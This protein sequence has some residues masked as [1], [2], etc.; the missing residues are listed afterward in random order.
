MW[1]RI[2]VCPVLLAAAT[3]L[4]QQPVS[5]ITGDPLS[6]FQMDG[7]GTLSVVDVTGEPFQ[8]ALH[9]ETPV[10]S[11]NLYDIRARCYSTST[12]NQGDV[13]VATFWM[14]TVSSQSGTGYTMFDVEKGQSPYSKS[15]LWPTRTGSDWEMKQVPFVMA[16]TYPSSNG[17]TANGYNIDFWVTFEPQ[18]IE[19]GGLTVLN[20]GPNYPLSNLG[21]SLQPYDG[22]DPNASWR[23][24]AAARIEQIRKADIVAVVHDANGNPLPGATVHVKMKRHAFPFGTSISSIGLL[25]QSDDAEKYRNAVRTLFNSAVIENDL[26]WP[27]WETTGNSVALPALDWLSQNG[28]TNLRG[29]NLIWPSKPNLPPDVVS[30]LNQPVVDQ[31]AL[32]ARIQSHFADIM[33]ATHGKLTDWDV[34]N[35]PYTNTDVQGVLGDDE[36]AAWF[37]QARAIDLSVKLYL[38]D[39]GF[40][41]SGG[42][43]ILHQDALYNH[44]IPTIL[45]SGDLDGIG[46]QA[47]FDVSLTP[48]ER[49]I[50]ILDRFAKF[51]KDIKITEFDVTTTDEQLQADYTRDFL[52]AVF[53]HPAVKGFTVWGFYEGAEWSPEAAMIRGDWTTKPN[54]DVWMNLVYKQWWT[55]VTGTT[56][57]DGT[58]RT[59][60]FLGDYDIDV[61]T[62]NAMQTLPLTVT[63]PGPNYL[64]MGKQSAGALTA[65]GVVNAAS[66]RGGSI[67]PGETIEIWGSNFGPAAPAFS[68][69]DSSGQLP[70]SV[71]D[72]RVLINGSP[73]PVGRVLPG[74]VTAIVPY[75][76]SGNATIQVQYLGTVTNAVTVPVQPASPGIFCYYGGSSQA[77][78]VNDL[79]DGTTSLNTA[80]HPVPRGSYVTIYVTGV[81]QIT[82]AEIVGMRPAAGSDLQPVLP[83]VV[84]FGDSQASCPYNWIGLVDAGVTQ[85]NACVPDNAP[86]G[87]AIPLSVTIGGIAAQTG[88]TIAIR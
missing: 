48:P 15:I 30:M 59:R 86:T 37:K 4:A 79:P 11:G 50:E 12:A 87:S 32:R 13:M 70:T 35:E 76:A 26:K 54:Y 25:V 2:I 43:D 31:N 77:V 38:N 23:A 45:A 16:E 61:T 74:R 60:G 51:G 6:C 66:F 67:A 58:F 73:A 65:A 46:M 24:A 39:F 28:L 53:S 88:V 64:L 72:T 34:L 47:H 63:S 18:V 20:Y 81:G 49:V 44:I 7:P 10:Y 29:H 19:I 22:H 75:A 69:Y 17:A 62:N 41:E 85:I 83:L 5:A 80:D 68:N 33:G 42:Y 36:M 1:L 3:A 56:G 9:I 71:G 52:T 84:K 55:D 8:K 57:A 27:I 78:V 21:L 14:R 40:L 82:P